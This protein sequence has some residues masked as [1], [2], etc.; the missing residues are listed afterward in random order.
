M[1]IEYGDS[2]T[3]LR[4]YDV[5]AGECIRF[6]KPVHPKHDPYDLFMVLDVPSDYEPRVAS[7][8]EERIAV[9]NIRTGA[10]AFVQQD[11][12]CYFVQVAA[13]VR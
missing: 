3:H 5:S 11:R 13:H 4:L 2:S 10:L 6:R 12:E 7:K 9:V 1:D 8:V